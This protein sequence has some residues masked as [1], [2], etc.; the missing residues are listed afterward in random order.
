MVIIVAYSNR[1]SAHPSLSVSMST[2]SRSVG[3]ARYVEVGQ[4]S[5]V[6]LVAVVFSRRV[7]SLRKLYAALFLPSPEH[8]AG[9]LDW[10]DQHEDR[11]EVDEG[12]ST[13][14]RPSA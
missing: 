10:S 3:L 4:R 1:P 5:R 14:H 6:L 13:A 7:G 8:L 9:P 12:V 11:H 2:A